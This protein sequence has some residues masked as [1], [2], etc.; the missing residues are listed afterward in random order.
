MPARRLGWIVITCCTAPGDDADRAALIEID[1]NLKRGDLS[2][3]ER[4]IHIAKRKEIYERLHPETKLGGAPAK[5]GPGKGG[6]IGK[7]AK[8]AV[9]P[10]G[11][12]FVETIAKA[13]GRSTR[14]VERDATRSKHIPMLAHCVDT[15]L[16]KGE[17]LDA[18]AKLPLAK[19]KE[20][21]TRARSGERVSA[22]NEAKKTRREEREKELAE[23]TQIASEELGSKLYN[24]IYADP[25]WPIAGDLYL[26]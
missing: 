22:R 8:L 5:T 25:P 4:G 11:P 20:L 15:S 17:E 9:L 2:P 12:S 26:P 23:A 14:S 6:K 24:V 13:S 1:E 10:G 7:D 18:L 21:I 3:A 16:D 19:Q